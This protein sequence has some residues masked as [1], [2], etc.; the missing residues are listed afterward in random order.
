V[1]KKEFMKEYI[2]LRF[3]VQD[4]RGDI[5]E[6]G[7]IKKLPE[8]IIVPKYFDDKIPVTVV[9]LR[10]DTIGLFIKGEM[11]EILMGC[12]PAIG[13]ELIKQNRVDDARVVQEIVL[14]CVSLCDERNHDDFIK[15][16]NQQ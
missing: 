3:G 4:S 13:F 6:P 9:S 2:V 7:C 10:Q 14:R 1:V 8:T 5:F 11:P 16:L 15:P 12:T